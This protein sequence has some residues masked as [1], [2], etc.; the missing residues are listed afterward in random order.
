MLKF[1][2]RFDTSSGLHGGIRNDF[3]RSLPDRVVKWYRYGVCCA[4]VSGI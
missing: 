3:Y 1:L 4:K 2:R